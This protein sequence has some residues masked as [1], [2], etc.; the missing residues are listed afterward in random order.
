M[1]SRRKLLAVLKKVKKLLGTDQTVIDNFDTYAGA[2]LLSLSTINAKVS[3]VLKSAE[4]CVAD[5]QQC[6][7]LPYTFNILELFAFSR[8]SCFLH[9][10]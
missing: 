10:A 3:L 7:S 8:P 2:L 4:L 1:N 5:N 6:R 9:A